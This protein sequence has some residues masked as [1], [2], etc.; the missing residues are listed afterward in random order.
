MQSLIPPAR[1]NL[2]RAGVFVR[3][4]HD[5]QRHTLTL[6]AQVTQLRDINGLDDSAR[7]VFR[8]KS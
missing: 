3:V 7:V 6:L 4:R 5:A 8:P 2:H 1:A